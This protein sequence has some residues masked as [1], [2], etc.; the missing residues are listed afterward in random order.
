MVRSI[1]AIA[2]RQAWGR[3]GRVATRP[4]RFVD[5]PRVAHLPPEEW[6]YDPG[7]FALSPGTGVESRRS[8]DSPARRPRSPVC[9]RCVQEFEMQVIRSRSASTD[10]CV[11]SMRRDEKNPDKN[12]NQPVLQSTCRDNYFL[13]AC[14]GW[15]AWCRRTG[16]GVF[17]RNAWKF[18]RDRA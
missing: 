12:A 11:L 13:G 5:T 9:S 6:N 8:H 18:F 14:S 4:V 2:I 15:K 10:V 7:P 1:G 3:A 16:I 17:G